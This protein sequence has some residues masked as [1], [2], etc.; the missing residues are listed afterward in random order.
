LL[1]ST[2]AV[3]AAFATGA[4]AVGSGADGGSFPFDELVFVPCANGGAG[5][6]V[7]LSGSLHFVFHTTFDDTG[8][9]HLQ[10]HDDLQGVSGTGMTTGTTFRGIQGDLSQFNDHPDDAPFES[11]SISSMRI[12]GQG[13]NNN[14]VLHEGAHFT[15]NANG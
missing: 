15:V 9:R 13:P 11:S 4:G 3:A 1:L 10:L 12:V 7:E 5:E 6:Y 8:G 14:F 2:A